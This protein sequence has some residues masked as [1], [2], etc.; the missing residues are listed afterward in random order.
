MW[1]AS[2]AA[3]ISSHIFSNAERAP[4][5]SPE[6]AK[7]LCLRY[8]CHHGIHGTDP[9]ALDQVE[10]QAEVRAAASAS[11]FTR[12]KVAF[13]PSTSSTS[14]SAFPPR[15]VLTRNCETLDVPVGASR[16]SV[17]LVPVAVGSSS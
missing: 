6:L 1:S 5:R 14:K 7:F 17:T 12:F 13:M 3:L 16:R 10:G 4:A 15:T 11:L 8:L 2:G 9:D